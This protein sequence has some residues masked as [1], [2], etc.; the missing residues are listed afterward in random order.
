MGHSHEGHQNTYIPIK[1]ADH[2]GKSFA[3]R[4]AWKSIR[5]L[6]LIS[7]YWKRGWERGPLSDSRNN[8]HEGWARSYSK[9]LAVWALQ[10]VCRFTVKFKDTLELQQS[11]FPNIRMRT[12]SVE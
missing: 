12:A 4:L 3:L 10:T 6:E 11:P 1:S 7:L 9:K 2:V 5:H 8:M